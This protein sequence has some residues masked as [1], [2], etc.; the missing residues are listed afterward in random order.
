M[1]SCCNFDFGKNEDRLPQAI[2][3]PYLSVF[4]EAI[5]PIDSNIENNLEIEIN[6]SYVSRNLYKLENE[7]SNPDR[8]LLIGCVLK[9][10]LDGIGNRIVPI[11]LLIAIDTSSSMNSFSTVDNNTN[12]D[13]YIKIAIDTVI[14][15][16]PKLKSTDRVGLINFNSRSTKLFDID[17]IS[18]VDNLIQVVSNLK[19]A[20][21]TQISSCVSLSIEM[22]EDSNKKLKEEIR[23]DPSSKERILKRTQRLLLL[24][25][26]CNDSSSDEDL[27]SGILNLSEYYN[28]NTSVIGIGDDVD[29]SLTER[30][31]KSKGFNYF[32]VNTID[33]AKKIINDFD[34][35][36]FPLA[37]NVN[38]TVESGDFEV[39]KVYGTNFDNV[40]LNLE[41][42]FNLTTIWLSSP[43]VR[44]SSL[45]LIHIF[46]KNKIKRTPK[47]I[48]V[49]FLEFLSYDKK[50]KN[51]CNI[52]SCSSTA[53]Y[54]NDEAKGKFF[55]IV[56]K[57]KDA[58]YIQKNNV[59]IKAKFNLQYED[60]SDYSSLKLKEFESDYNN[61]LNKS[62]NSVKSISYNKNYFIKDIDIAQVNGNI[63]NG[64]CLF[65]Y[66]KFL[67]DICRK[68]N[69]IHEKLIPTPNDIKEINDN[70]FL[71]EE[72]LL[73]CTERIK[74]FIN[75]GFYT[76][77]HEL[78]NNIFKSMLDTIELSKKS[79]EKRDSN[80][81]NSSLSFIE[82]GVLLAQDLI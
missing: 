54:S 41:K 23:L 35:I 55:I 17:Y 73:K 18:N 76:D 40:A 43:I 25:D 8:D 27:I 42:Q 49:N 69:R 46:N 5:T 58:K 15:I 81:M 72:N 10:K 77:N 1:N 44:L 29:I 3:K 61:K 66:N 16:L 64:L 63:H 32:T 68:K 51:V 36:F 31:S 24:T 13:S 45:V 14:H 33:K 21:G 47:P 57:L 71:E 28:I 74:S 2:S 20:G 80:S 11:D 26:M 56:A 79:Y 53:K 22:F 65:Y 67:R 48:I 34:M 78:K 37:T 70:L 59:E 38:M 6:Y 12:E 60:L 50:I 9:S 75:K 39:K 62:N 19:A 82:P 4:S 52:S 7:K 30:V